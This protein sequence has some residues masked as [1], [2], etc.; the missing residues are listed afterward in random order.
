MLCEKQNGSRTLWTIIFELG[1]SAAICLDGGVQLMSLNVSYHLDGSSTV[2]K[3]LSFSSL[4][5]M[6]TAFPLF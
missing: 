3:M 6:K 4:N 5:H 2:F 1:Q